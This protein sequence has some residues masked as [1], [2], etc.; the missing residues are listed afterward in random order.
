MYPVFYFMVDQ[1]LCTCTTTMQ[2]MGMQTDTAA[3]EISMTISQKIKKQPTSRPRNLAMYSKDAQPYH[4]CI[5]LAMFIAALFV[6]ARTWKQPKCPLSEEWIKKMWYIYS[7]QYYIVGKDNETL[8]FAG[9]WMD[10]E[11][12]Y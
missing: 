7:M 8:K 3:L 5:C 12:S 1:L 4:K 10:L 6:I 2:V 11:I 9:K